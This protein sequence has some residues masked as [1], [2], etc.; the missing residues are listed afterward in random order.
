[1]FLHSLLFANFFDLIDSE[2]VEIRSHGPT[3]PFFRIISSSC[4]FPFFVSSTYI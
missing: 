3:P 2:T 4:I 1:M